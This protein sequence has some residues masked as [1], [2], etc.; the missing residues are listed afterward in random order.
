MSATPAELNRF[1]RAL[2]WT[3]LAIGGLVIVVR[4]GAVGVVWYLHHVR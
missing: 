2:F 1:E 4:L 3:A